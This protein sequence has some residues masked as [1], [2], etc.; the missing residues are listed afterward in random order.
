[1][2][3]FKILVYLILLFS[4][5]CK[6]QNNSS[7]K[8]SDNILQAKLLN[9]KALKLSV[10]NCDKD[11]I[12][13]S[14]KLFEQA[15]KLD[16]T[17]PV[18]YSNESEM[19]CNLRKY[20]DAIKVLNRFLYN[21]PSNPALETLKGHIFERAGNMDSAMASYLDIIKQY[22]LKI[23]NDPN[24]VSIQL[25]R[26]FLLFFT[27]GDSAAK[28]EFNRISKK[29]PQDVRVEAMQG[30]FRSFERKS[31]ITQIFSSCLFPNPDDSSNTSIM[32]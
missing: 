15:I 7:L 26:A 24:N 5:S 18:F 27:Q 8:K 16:N 14:I 6:S 29:F 32:H 20:Q 17:V 28:K 21:F 19:Y 4:A 23:Q 31:Y 2:N 9:D 1:M 30:D 3:K 13:K 12:E 22:N 25:N 11:S 10:N